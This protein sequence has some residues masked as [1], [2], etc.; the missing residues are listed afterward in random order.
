MSWA[1]LVKK[2]IPILSSSILTNSENKPQKVETSR[3][4]V[5]NHSETRQCSQIR[6]ASL[7]ECL[8]YRH[9][10][11]PRANVYYSGI[12]G[13]SRMSLSNFYRLYQHQ[14]Q[15]LYKN[16]IQS[17]CQEMGTQSPSLSSFVVLAWIFSD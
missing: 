16:R 15:W 7:K 14:L 5:S 3:E 12:S 17:W 6:L 4:E 11:N 8:D 1:N 2:T 9:S 13:K 10:G